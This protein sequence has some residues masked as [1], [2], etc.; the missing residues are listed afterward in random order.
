MDVRQVLR[1]VARGGLKRSVDPGG[2]D[3]V[4]L[5]HDPVPQAGA[6]GDGLGEVEPKVPETC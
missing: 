1:N 5:V 2:V 6:G 3:L 4:V